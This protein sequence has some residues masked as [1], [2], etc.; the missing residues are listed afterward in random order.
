MLLVIPREIHK[1]AA[2]NLLQKRQAGKRGYGGVINLDRFSLF[3]EIFAFMCANHWNH[4]PL[5]TATYATT[6][7]SLTYKVSPP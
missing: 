7:L 1:L 6:A 3:Q 5:S 4:F 2:Q